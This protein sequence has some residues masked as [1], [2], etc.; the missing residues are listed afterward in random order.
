MF[1]SVQIHQKSQIYKNRKLTKRAI[2]SIFDVPGTDTLNL[3]SRA[4]NII[5]VFNDSIE[6]Q[7]HST[8][9][10]LEGIPAGPD[11]ETRLTIMN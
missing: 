7:C 3:Y 2:W 5:P 10:F 1:K 9:G 8:D 4:T 11:P 6:F